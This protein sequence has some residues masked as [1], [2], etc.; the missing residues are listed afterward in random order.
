MIELVSGLPLGALLGGL[1]GSL[2]LVPLLIQLAP[3]L[4]LIAHANERSS[5]V[6]PTP[7]GGGIAIALPVLVWCAVSPQPFGQYLAIGGGI[8]ALIGVI[9]DVFDLP[10]LFRFLAQISV[11][12][13]FISMAWPDATLA[14]Q[15]ITGFGMLW[16]LNL[17][18]F[19]DG[20]DGL[21]ASQALLYCLGVLLLTG[22]MLTWTESLLWMISGS[23]LGFLLFNWPPARV[24]MGDAGALLLGLSLP[25]L[26]IELDRTGYLPLTVS[27]LLVVVFVFDASWT[28][29]VRVI[30]G[31][32][33]TR[34]HRSHLYQRLAIT[35]GH[36]RTTTGFVLYFV[37]IVLPLAWTMTRFEVAAIWTF[38][39]AILPLLLLS[40]AHSAGRAPIAVDSSD[41]SDTEAS[42]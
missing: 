14:E 40:F 33:I 42:T 9:D 30:T 7:T 16:F 23:C 27:L 8:V 31:Q 19:M 20:I 35:Y 36:L 3:R 2:L 17:F 1:I 12:G 28:L 21:A 38:S 37:M 15:L 25:A 11:I 10:A 4:R 22:A 34:A 6:R 29:G 26:A 18:N 32:R 41:Q 24:F 5:H 39:A 13:W